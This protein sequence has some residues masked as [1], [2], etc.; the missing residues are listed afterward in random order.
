MTRVAWITPGYPPDRGGVSDH[1]Y[2]M[3]TTL[4]EQGHEVLV[5]SRPHERSFKHL[6]AELLRFH[7]EAVIVAYVPLGFAPRSGGLS[8]SFTLWCTQLRRRLHT[9]T[10][11]IAHEV[12][13][14]VA[15]HWSRHELKLALLGTAQA[16]QFELL[17]RCFDQIAFSHEASRGIWA[18]RLP[19]LRSRLHTV[20]ICSSISVAHSL[21]P[22]ADLAAAGYSV[23]AHTVIFFGTGHPSVS[24]EYV[25]RAFRALLAAEP[26]A[27]LII[28]GMDA[29]KL[30]TIRPTLADLGDRVRPLGFVAAH[31]VSLWFQVARL[32]LLPFVDGVNARKTT[33]MAALQHGRA[34][35]TTKGVNTRED[36]PWDRLCAVAPLEP[37]AFA[38]V[39][40]ECFRNAHWREELGAAG[41]ADYDAHA[42]P[43][44][45]AAQFLA[46]ATGSR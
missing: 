42:S 15:E 41:K 10:L 3:T 44:V 9:P 4:R 11:L 37:A 35:A 45:T 33:V 43:S 19:N 34:V 31:E 25:E 30:R 32:V 7:P 40:L 26:E 36:I 27:R 6:T 5:S 38:T 1:S 29:A 24:F 20:R 12:C 22:A 23:P 39:A 13:L 46:C 2:A 21:D 18:K 16:T 8:P 14:P 28:I 17:A